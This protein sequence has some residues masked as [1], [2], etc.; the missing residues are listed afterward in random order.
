MEVYF[1]LLKF[2]RPYRARF[3]L[4][5]LCMLV[6]SATNGALAY[7]FGPAIKTLFSG[8]GGRE[9]L[10][11]AGFFDIK[12]SNPALFVVAAITIIAV[13]KGFSSYGNTY[14]MG[15]VGQMA[16]AD[17]RRKL[18]DHILRLPYG[19][20]V[21]NSTGNLTSR[22]TNDIQVL[23]KLTAETLAVALKQMLAAIALAAVILAIDWKLALVTFIVLP[24]ISYP[25]V[26]FG[27]AMKRVSGK[28]QVTMGTIMSFL[29][30]AISGIRIVKGFG[31]E[32]YESERF[33]REN[34]RFARYVIKAVKI[35]GVSIPLMET[36]G[37]VGFAFAIWYASQ[38]IT[39]GTLTAEE[40]L[41]FFAAA[42]MLYQPLKALNAVH[43]D[44]QQGLASAIRIFEVM[45][46]ETER[47]D[48]AGKKT[49]G[50]L[51]QGIEFRNV[52]FNYGNKEILKDVSLNI[53]KGERVAIVGASGA[54]KTTFVNLIPRF[55]DVTGGAI[56]VDGV[57]T[58]D[59]ALGRLRSLVAIVSQDVTL[60]DDTIR[61]NIAYGAL[62]CFNT[63]RPASKGIGAPL[64][65]ASAVEEAAKAANADG[66]ISKLP[67]G[68]DTVIGEGGARLSGGE[69]Q[70]LSIARAFFK[71]APILI[72]DE[73]TS[74]LDSVSEREVERSLRGLMEGRTA[75]IIAHRLSTV[76]NAD[77]IIVLSGGRIV[78]SG[79]HAELMNLKGEYS[80]L[81]SMQ[82]AGL[83]EGID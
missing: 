74:S 20:F 51:S 41:S 52:S 66:F 38:R 55:Y 42:I 54:G 76:K 8:S 56:L 35:K 81:Y 15:Y 58:R 47:F 3:I 29:H 72:M 19:Y 39:A 67:A 33:G 7:L 26:R 48:E 9:I 27:K 65:D 16:I 10:F 32:S 2:V 69:R 57:D 17:L 25:L 68:Y 44:V 79:R 64:N 4:A 1:R 6:F 77:R 30:E 37:A 5:S 71:N 73:A 70:R 59:I 82:F 83:K 63:E 75:F 46:M 21:V 13:L 50:G 78:E 60:F 24:L 36:L 45:D 53:K 34:Y 80:R 12:T 14:L 22:L 18:Y 31:M 43:L 49:L 11:R 62:R 28:G 23:Q 40:F 61:N